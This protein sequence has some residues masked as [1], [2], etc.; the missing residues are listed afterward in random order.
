MANTRRLFVDGP[1]GQ[2]HARIRSAESQT[3]P[4]LVCLH[5]FPQSGRNFHGFLDAA[6]SDRSVV[7]LDFPGHGESD[8]PPHPI[9]AQDYARAMWAAID[10]LELLLPFGNIDLF[11]VHA[12]AKLTIAMTAQR[13]DNVRK[14][15]L[16]SAAVMMPSEVENLKQSFAPRPLDEEG[17]RFSH[18]WHLI[19][20]NRPDYM[21]LED[22]SVL[23]AEILRGG[24]KYEWGHH[25]VFEYNLVFP[26]V[27]KTIEQPV[28]LLNPH[29]ELREMTLRSL[30]YLTNVE[31]F[32]LPNWGHGF[33]E[34]FPAQV[35][36]L[37][38]SWLDRDASKNEPNNPPTSVPK[39][40][41]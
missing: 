21:T 13:P 14:I 8:A 25:A 23:F 19:V 40:L 16:S 11:G 22:C 1:Y 3:S 10:E 31:L 35:A 15:V 36:D 32:D 12:G 33:I 5:M 24:E 4:P 20:R 7:A 18:L 30:D 29:D 38:F 9:T 17:S 6:V 2:M 26:D 37:V 28:A 41:A 34:A 39:I 27:L